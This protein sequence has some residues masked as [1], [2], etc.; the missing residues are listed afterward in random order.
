[1]FD[2]LDYIKTFLKIDNKDQVKLWEAIF[3][4][5][6]V[7][8]RKR[9]PVELLLAQRPNEEESILDYRLR[10]YRAIT[11]GSMNRA[12]DSAGRL[13]NKTQYEVVCPDNVKAYLNKKQFE[14]QNTAYDFYTY[15]E[16]ITF[17]RT[18][19][20]P[21]GFLVWL[22]TG[23]G[24]F[25]NSVTV[26]PKPFFFCLD[27]I[28]DITPEIVSFLSD[29]VNMITENGKQVPGEVFY[30]ITKQ[31]FY[32]LVQVSTD[33]RK[34]YRLDPIYEYKI[35]EIPALVLGGDMNAE[36]YFESYFAPYCAFGDEAI[37]TFSDWQAIK[38]T[39]GFPYREEFYT[40]CEIKKPLKSASPVPI[41]E[42]KY[43]KEVHLDKFP[44]TPYNTIIRK[45]PGNK[46]DAEI[47]G[48]R[49]LPADIPSL[50]FISP[51]VKVME[52]QGESWATLIEK[53]EDALHLNLANGSNQSGVAK[54]EDTKQ[55]QA[56][57]DK[58]GN[59]YFNHQMVNSIK[60]IDC[61]LNLIPF[62]KS[63]I[64]VNIPS[65]FIIPTTAELVAEIGDLKVKNAPS[66]FIAEVTTELAKRKFN[67]SPTSKKIFDFI[68]IINPLFTYSVNEQ[69]QMLNS[70]GISQEEY[71][72]SIHAYSIVQRMALEMPNF[73][74]AT[75]P[76]IETKFNEL[77]QPYID[78]VAMVPQFDASGNPIPP[79]K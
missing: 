22:P 79:K 41:G 5:M 52:Y 50:R 56:M 29:E 55:E 61:Y 78:A 18:I 45:I 39:S 36:G 23:E 30:L 47:N 15:S 33:K 46:N 14:A 48:E 65:S 68:S 49:I 26:D 57:I 64:E 24:I 62:E 37:S 76:V 25:N 19:E 67:G 71:V 70:N 13:L 11:Y 16:K 8:T 59:N 66:I 40:E 58:I 17:K 72:R 9:K 20:D 2:I 38:V 34:K 35:G 21:N 51:D 3:Y 60:F 12:L 4:Q 53:A 75:I 7:H 74:D 1:M 63:K 32:K 54:K 27:K 28:R 6:A 44:R 10:N 77:L 31:W 42:Q 43:K 73:L 69:I